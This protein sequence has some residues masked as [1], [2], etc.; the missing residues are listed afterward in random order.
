MHR[1]RQVPLPVHVRYSCSLLPDG[2]HPAPALRGPEKYPRPL[3]ETEFQLGLVTHHILVPRRVENQRNVHTLHTRYFRYLRPDILHEHIGH[4]T[5]GSRQRHLYLRRPVGHI[6]DVVH[7]PQVIDID[8]NF[9]V[10]YILERSDYVLLHPQYVVRFHLLHLPFPPF[11][12]PRM[13]GRRASFAL[14]S[15]PSRWPA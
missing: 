3:H 7:E 4:G 1:E 15:P 10:V 5:V 9:R 14:S 6:V 12:P 8:R 13:P 2:T 11:R